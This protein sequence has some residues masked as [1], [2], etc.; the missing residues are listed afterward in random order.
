MFPFAVLLLPLARTGCSAPQGAAQVM[1][2]TASV[3]LWAPCAL[4]PG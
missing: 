4:G 3:C 1:A 2:L